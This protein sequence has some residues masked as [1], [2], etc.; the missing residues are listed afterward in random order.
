M[1]SKDDEY[2]VGE[3]NGLDPVEAH[4]VK[5]RENIRRLGEHPET[6]EL[7]IRWNAEVN[8][9][10][11]THN[12]SWM[13]RPLIQFPQDL[14]AMQ[15]LL[16]RI[17]PTL[18]IECGIAHG[19][20]LIFYASLMEMMGIDGE[21]LGIDVD[22][23]PHNFREITKHAMYKRITMIEG[24]SIEDRTVEKV[25]AFAEHHESILVCLDSNHTHDHVLRELRS[26]APL[27]SI[28][29]YCVV[30]DTG[31]DDMPAEDSAD[32]PW[33]PGNSPKSA[34]HQYL[35]ENRGFEID[36]EMVNKLLITAC[37][38]GYLKRIE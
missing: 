6:R 32:R 23:R 29:S 7:S 5:V 21:I 2:R 27:V 10:N 1:N 20:S 28:E 33:G 11:Y 36:H 38:D 13:G 16:W 30:F 26:Y 4:A 17:R 3:L 12:F 34:V 14:I 9:H 8:R 24:S 37:P 19:G 31:I 18:V 15:E 22:I 25:C 35:T